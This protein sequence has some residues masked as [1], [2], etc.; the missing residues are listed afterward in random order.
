MRGEILFSKNV[1]HE[2]GH[3][4]SQPGRADALTRDTATHG[5]RRAALRATLAWQAGRQ[6]G[7]YD[8]SGDPRV[9]GDP[10]LHV[11]AQTRQRL[12]RKPSSF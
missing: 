6:A 1:A 12:K 3:R 11:S 2:T 8:R 7:R 9:S 4:P 5:D 10:S